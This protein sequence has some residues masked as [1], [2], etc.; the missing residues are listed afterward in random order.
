M[1]AVS[2]PHARPGST[3]SMSPVRPPAAGAGPRSAT[4]TV[5]SCCEFHIWARA[6][7]YLPHNLVD[8]GLW[9]LSAAAGAFRKQTR[10]SLWTQ[11]SGSCTQLL[12]CHCC[13]PAHPPQRPGMA[14]GRSRAACGRQALALTHRRCRLPEG[15]RPWLGRW[16][17]RGRLAGNRHMS[18]VNACR[19]CTRRAVCGETQRGCAARCHRS[20]VPAR[21]PAQ[22][23]R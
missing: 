17:W 19:R 12:E 5:D 18:E 8:G 11:R 2:E 3:E 10:Q 9:L 16:S 21:S 22:R 1:C 7:E 14:H 15:T 13:Q 23:A 6:E 20:D 4:P